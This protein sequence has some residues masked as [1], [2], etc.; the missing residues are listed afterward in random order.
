V[1]HAVLFRIPAQISTLLGYVVLVRWLTETEF[2]VYS[3]FYAMLPMIG[4]LMSF[5]MENT[6]NRYQP[7]YLRKGENRLANRLSRNVGLLRLATTGVFC[8]TVLVFWSDIAPFFKIADYRE[9]FMLFAV[10]IITHFQCQILA[11]SLS[12]HLLQKYS[13]GLTAVFS[14]L[15]LSGYGLAFL[16]HV[17][18]LRTAIVV[19]LIA[20][21]IFYVC[22]K[23]AYMRKPDHRKGAEATLPPE[24]KKRLFRYAAYYSFN[25]VGTLTLD[26]RKDNFFIAALMDTVSVGAYAFAQRFNE[27][28]G[29]VSPMHLLESVVQPLFVSLDHKRDPQR[30]HRYFSLLM[31]VALGARLPLLAFTAAYHREIVLVLFDGRFLDYSYLLPVTA[32]FSLGFVISVPVTLVAQ[33]Q[34][35]AQFVLASKIFGVFGIAASI[36]LIPVMGVLGAVIAG[37]SAIVMKNLFIWWFVRDLARW[38]NAWR[39]TLRAALIWGGFALAVLLQQRWVAGNAILALITGLVIWSAFFLLQIRAAASPD[40]RRIV[41]DLFSGRER[42]FL[43]LLGVA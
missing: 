2:G 8:A 20:Y 43:R 33:L 32:M 25:D 37:G 17:F 23:Y 3:L 36:L 19:D 31:T 28:L 16:L 38:T 7:E 4:T 29:R 30:I 5:G 34:E 13:I 15:K 26:T 22:L 18:T 41:G 1:F 42:K 6:L 35:K 21:F 14:M 9:Q 11:I 12:A 39:F 40:E 24:E 27:M 10:L